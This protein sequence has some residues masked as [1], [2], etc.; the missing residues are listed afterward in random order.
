MENSVSAASRS[1]VEEDPIAGLSS[2]EISHLVE[3]LVLSDRALELHRLLAL[4]TA[5]KRNAWYETKRARSDVAGYL[6]DVSKAWTAAE[7]DGADLSDHIGLK[8]RYALLTSSARTVVADFPANLLKALVVKRVWPLE[9]VWSY[10]TQI[11]D[12]EKRLR[13]LKLLT[14][15]LPDRL[16]DESFD[17]WAQLGPTSLWST[18][19]ITLAPRLSASQVDR[20]IEL[21]IH[22]LYEPDKVRSFSAIAPYLA[23]RHFDLLFDHIHEEH[24][25][26]GVAGE[27]VAGLAHFVPERLLDTSIEIVC[28]DT[29]STEFVWSELAARLDASQIRHALLR[30]EDVSSF[31]ANRVLYAALPGLLSQL[32]RL[33]FLDEALEHIPTKEDVFAH[34]QFKIVFKLLPLM[35]ATWTSKRLL[36]WLRT[37]VPSDL[38]LAGGLELLSG[39]VASDSIPTFVKLARAMKDPRSRAISLCSIAARL[40]LHSKRAVLSEALASAEKVQD[41]IGVI[42]SELEF[43]SPAY[44][45]AHTLCTVALAMAA[46]GEPNLVL[47]AVDSALAIYRSDLRIAFEIHDDRDSYGELMAHCL[48]KITLCLRTK[49]L[50][51]HVDRIR[52]LQNDTLQGNAL[53]LAA[54]HLSAEVCE[55]ALDSAK[56][57]DEIIALAPFL[58]EKLLKHILINLYDRFIPDVQPCLIDAV[59]PYLREPLLLICVQM[60]HRIKDHLGQAV[61]LASLSSFASEED[62]E[63][64]A[65]RALAAAE[66][67][68]PYIDGAR[69]QALCDIGP[70]LPP[71]VLRLAIADAHKL[72]YELLSR[73]A[74]AVL[75]REL[76]RRG[77]SEEALGRASELAIDAGLEIFTSLSSVIAIDQV[78]RI[79]EVVISAEWNGS[80]EELMRT[81]APRLP[82]EAVTRV[83]DRFL[84]DAVS[85]RKLTMLGFLAPRVPIQ[86]REKV[87]TAARQAEDHELSAIVI[88]GIASSIAEKNT[89]IKLLK[90]AT[91]RLGP[92]YDQFNFPRAVVAIAA[93]VTRVSEFDELLAVVGVCTDDTAKTRSMAGLVRFLPSGLFNSVLKNLSSAELENQDE[94]GE[95]ITTEHA[96]RAD[97]LK[98]L[99]SY[100][101]LPESAR[102][103]AIK[104]IAP[105]LEGDQFEKVLRN[106]EYIDD[107][108]GARS[109]ILEGVI[110]HL[111]TDLV[112]K[113]LELVLAIPNKFKRKTSLQSIIRRVTI[114]KSASREL[115]RT[116]HF[117][118][119]QKRLDVLYDLASVVP[120]I[121][122]LGDERAIRSA[123]KAIDDAVLWWD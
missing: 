12:D 87:L 7:L 10:Y 29:W 48:G 112:P 22:E 30:I 77:Y 96:R 121:A 79:L 120:L 17:L 101:K 47:Q 35:A 60:V 31:N 1:V 97:P 43:H 99:D 85:D 38:V 113:A 123:I 45:R 83:I 28:D 15:I 21:F 73:P 41:S 104:G 32:A 59:A 84:D 122:L 95:A 116:L 3:H 58:P 92:K 26:S 93:A 80:A 106:L 105:Y 107:R 54:S 46:A 57:V 53:A 64:V 6:G 118:A 49:Q 39:L 65:T 14:P 91:S 117:W 81:A 88:A 109:R 56:N 11:Q 52:A 44:M 86:L 68:G 62:S 34:E 94:L 102:G 90:E 72:A 66:L 108:H 63:E 20:T 16:V 8:V 23:D 27:I 114:P 67:S 24:W 9:T 13:A 98:A 50:K 40:S 103:D 42:S 61:A 71:S 25:S 51:G 82:S 69:R 4:E 18:A 75:L 33:G 76:A 2:Y 89:R 37:S 74:L 119:S 100:F 70:F 78:E 115:D 110:P 111:P 19:L 36:E 5:A 55:Y